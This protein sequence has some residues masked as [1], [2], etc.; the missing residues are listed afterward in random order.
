MPSRSARAS[1]ASYTSNTWCRF[2]SPVSAS[3][4]LR[5]SASSAARWTSVTSDRM[6]C[7][8]S[9]PSAA[10]CGTSFS[11]RAACRRSRRRGRRGRRA[12]GWRAARTASRRRRPRGRP[13]AR[14][15][16]QNPGVEAAGRARRK[17]REPVEARDLELQDEAV[18]GMDAEREQPL[19][20]RLRGGDRRP[21]GRLPPRACARRPGGRRCASAATGRRRA[22]RRSRRPAARSAARAPEATRRC[23]S[24]RVSTRRIQRWPKAS[25]LVVARSRIGRPRR[26]WWCALQSAAT[27][28]IVAPPGKSLRARAPK[29]RQVERA[30]DD[31]AALAGNA[32]DGFDQEHGRCPE[33]AV[34]RRLSCG[35][36]A[37]DRGGER[38]RAARAP[39]DRGRGAGARPPAARRA[40]QGSARR[41]RRPA[42]LAV[43]RLLED[44]AGLALVRRAGRRRQ[45]GRP[46]AR[47]SGRG[48]PTTGPPGCET[49]RR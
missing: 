34:D 49:R 9:R 36:R 30:D 25:T 10:R 7:T 2:A 37:A 41:G 3:V 44:R 47:R 5:C 40:R 39:R 17:S 46:E 45:R 35:V 27:A 43:G 26:K 1:S 12:R 33:G 11:A 22:G 38:P 48:R 14:C 20:D 29:P 4:R 16:R 28:T 13:G 19:L 15:T 21:P 23:R 18:V 31:A 6:P 32:E 24:G 8:S 42:P